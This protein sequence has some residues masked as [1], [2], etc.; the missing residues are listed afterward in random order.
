MNYTR[1]GISFFCLSG[2]LGIHRN[3]KYFFFFK[4]CETFLR[5]SNNRVWISQLFLK[6]CQNGTF[7]PLHGIWNLFWPK[8]DSLYYIKK[9]ALTE[10]TLLH[11]GFTIPQKARKPGSNRVKKM[12][13]V[14]IDILLRQ[15]CIK[16]GMLLQKWFELIVVLT[17]YFFTCI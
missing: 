15:L 5:D 9:D 2:S 11:P 8:V 10:L 16:I 6:N 4:S 17:S 12:L 14:T 3:P 7:E 1:I 13:C